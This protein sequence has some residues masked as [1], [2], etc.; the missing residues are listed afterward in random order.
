MLIIYTVLAILYIASVIQCY[1][2]FKR[3]ENIESTQD[4]ILY[5]IISLCSSW[6]ALP[7]Y[8]LLKRYFKK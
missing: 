6:I 8:Y 2:V 4:K 5:M 3:E 1:D 7:A